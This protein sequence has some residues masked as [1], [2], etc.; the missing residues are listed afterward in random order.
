[1]G[2]RF[3]LVG[4]AELELRSFWPEVVA[5]GLSSCLV[6]FANANKILMRTL[7]PKP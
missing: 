7:N 1:M 3:R 6:F 4:D 2:G 5:F